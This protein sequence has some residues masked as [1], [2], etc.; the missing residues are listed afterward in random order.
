MTTSHVLFAPLA[1]ASIIA[2]LG[3]C[4]RADSMSATS[5]DLTASSLDCGGETTDWPM[6]GQ[7]ICNTRAAKSGGLDVDSVR[8][9]APKWIY[10]AAG[11]ISATPAVVEGSVYVPD[12]SGALSRLDA[13]TGN[14]IW[15]KSVSQ[16]LGLSSGVVGDLLSGFLAR[17]TPVVTNDSVIFGTR[18][19]AA[20]VLINDISVANPN[21][22]LAAVDKDTAALKW[23]TVLDS[24]V[25]AIITGSPVLFEGRVFQGVSSGEEAL[26][27]L[28]WHRCCT[29]RGSVAAVDA[30]TGRIIWQTPM[31]RDDLY[32]DRN[33]QPSGYS[34]APVWSSTPVID[35]KRRQLYVTTG[36]QYSAPPGVT[37]VVDG[38]YFESI[39]ALDI[40]SGAIRWAT[41][42]NQK[43]DTFTLLTGGDDYDFGAGANLF[44]ATIDGRPTDLVGAGQKSGVYWAL[45]ADSGH[46]V[47]SS[48]VGPGGKLGGIH[49]GTATDGARIYSSLNNG[50]SVAITVGG[51]GAHAGRT[52]TAGVWSALDPASGELQWQTPLP[53]MDRA[54]HGY[55]LNGPVSVVNGVVFGGAMDDRGTMF[56]LDAATGEVLW[57]FPSGGTVYGGPAIANGVVYWGSGYGTTGTGTSSKKLYAFTPK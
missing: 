21:A 12:W 13:Q 19:Q 28:P 45:D 24:H 49:W 43:I 20:N 34:G 23:K 16:L 48:R 32:F 44:T 3:A 52:T 54:R 39:V 53:T 56:A 11:D 38:N 6:A 7:N 47:W 22:Y 33:H 8:R 2:C 42:L 35:K 29:F 15:S 41:Q 46:V 17:A 30:A 55:S 31:I 27:D 57:T 26:G 50:D 40:D 51:H 37:K 9:L 1:I 5:A 25:A 4:A 36:N 14:V 10:S 18:R